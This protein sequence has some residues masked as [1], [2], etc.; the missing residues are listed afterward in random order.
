MLL[1]ACYTINMK[2]CLYCKKPLIKKEKE[3]PSAWKR[4]IFCNIDCRRHMSHYKTHG[5][6]STRT[7]KTC[8]SCGVYKSLAKFALNKNRTDGTGTTCRECKRVEG[9][10]RKTGW[11]QKEY[12]KEYQIQNGIC[13]I[14]GCLRKIGAADHSHETGKTRGLLCVK[15]NVALHYFDNLAERKAILDYLKKYSKE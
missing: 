6:P 15:H 11:S 1:V 3:V 10:L 9:R 8:P 5:N 2:A 7:H 13:A 12:Q 4:R 14:Q